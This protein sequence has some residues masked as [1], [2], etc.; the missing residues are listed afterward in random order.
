MLGKWQNMRGMWVIEPLLRSMHKYVET[1]QT[2]YQIN[3][4]IVEIGKALPS[5]EVTIDSKAIKFVEKCKEKKQLQQ[6]IK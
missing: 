6:K 4:K 5:F 3:N 2:I 1:K